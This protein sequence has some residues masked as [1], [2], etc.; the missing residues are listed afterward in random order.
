[1]PV[2][3]ARVLE[4]ISEY[5]LISAGQ[6]VLVGL[7]GGPDS[8]AL[9]LALHRLSGK[10]QITLH[11]ACVDHGLRSESA[12]EAADVAAQCEALGIPCV[13]RRVD[14]VAKRTAH[15]SWQDAARRARL[16][17]LLEAAKHH[18]CDVV[19]L[20][21][22]AQDQ[23]ETILFR[24]VRGTGVRGLG[25]IPY[26]RDRFVRP[27]LDVNRSEIER[28][29]ARTGIVVVRDPSNENPRYARVRVRNEWLP[30]L[31]KENPKIV[32]ALL[33][34]SADARRLALGVA[35]S[36]S[37]DASL[38]KLGL[39]RR[40]GAVID[41]LARKGG[42]SKVSVRG[43]SVVV[44]YGGTRFVSSLE[45]A[46]V[47][48]HGPLALPLFLGQQVK[49]WGHWTVTFVR[50]VEPQVAPQLPQL[51]I[52]VGEFDCEKIVWPLTLR[53]P[54]PG[55]RMRPR[56]AQGSRKLQDLFVDAKV[57][58]PS[59]SQLPVVVDADGIV[60]FVPRARPAEAARPKPETRDFLTISAENFVIS[61]K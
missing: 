23:A 11:A 36:P 45:P 35:V 41:R 5:Q 24:I 57:P 30:A 21:H 34:L 61:P 1:M 25:G 53:Q 8:W 6:R 4:T 31:A 28:F 60:L 2:L 42:T 12:Q 3:L 18:E 13:V 50:S 10:L 33:A 9:L 47:V 44:S 59:R 26:K 17:A 51:G 54:C 7:S 43:G 22:N 27:I 16:E 49:P 32:D 39:S 14:V 56:G 40:Q 20:G 58:Q 29:I 52:T 55:D 37:L 48:S 46:A 15:V 19:A 38:G